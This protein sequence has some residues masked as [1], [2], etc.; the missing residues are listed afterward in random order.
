VEDIV[1]N[2][3]SRFGHG[4]SDPNVVFVRNDVLQLQIEIT[5]HPNESYEESVEGLQHDKA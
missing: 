2:A 3:L 5:R 1:G 4:T